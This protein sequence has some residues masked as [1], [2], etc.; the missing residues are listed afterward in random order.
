MSS[1]EVSTN[2]ITPHALKIQ[3]EHVIPDELSN[4]LLHQFLENEAIND[5]SF[6]WFKKNL[7][8]TEGKY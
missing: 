2:L 7:L 5:I 6:T 4:H 8:F 3:T 1:H